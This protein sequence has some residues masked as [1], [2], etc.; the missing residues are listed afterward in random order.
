MKAP[1]LFGAAAIA[2]LALSRRQTHTAQN[3]EGLSTWEP[4][5][6][7]DD[8][9]ARA[10]E[11]MNRISGTSASSMTTS[12]EMIARLK[13]RERLMLARYEL[14]DG[15]WSIGYGHFTPYSQT[16]PP[17]S[18]SREEAEAMFLRDLEDRAQRWVRA[19]VTV[20][21]TQSQ[22]DALVSMAFNLSPASF[23]TIAEVV[24]AGGDPREQAM[25]FVRPDKPHLTQGLI[26]RREEELAW[27]WREGSANHFG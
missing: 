8:V 10:A 15:G 11:V 5:S 12:P 13:A 19:Y 7:F 21:L 18:I 1:L 25:K 22:F 3:E 6:V 20:P 23:C 16:P 24:N 27:Y 17:A 4:L 26:N 14:G 2:L 9:T